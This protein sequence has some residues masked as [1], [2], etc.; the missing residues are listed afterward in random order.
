MDCH[1]C[2]FG[3][4]IIYIMAM[5][6]S[7]MNL[8]PD[9]VLGNTHHIAKLFMVCSFHSSLQIAETVALEAAATAVEIYVV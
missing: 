3:K 1:G 8:S 6:E 7:H 4:D 2:V 9:Y 5:H